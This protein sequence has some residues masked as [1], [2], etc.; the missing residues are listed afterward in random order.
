MSTN[1]LR[2]KTKI[3]K[4]LS[5]DKTALPRSGKVLESEGVYKQGAPIIG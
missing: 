1:S 4:V 3:R 5:R 2:K